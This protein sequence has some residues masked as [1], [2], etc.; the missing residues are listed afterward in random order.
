[1]GSVT[2]QVFPPL[3]GGYISSDVQ[4]RAVLLLDHAFPQLLLLEGDD[5]STVGVRH[6]FFLLQDLDCLLHAFLLERLAGVDVEFNVQQR[7]DSLILLDGEISEFLPQ[8]EG[9]LV[10]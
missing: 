3:G 1:M 6:E 2:Y 4:S 9:F 7:V 10:A 5:L 8:F